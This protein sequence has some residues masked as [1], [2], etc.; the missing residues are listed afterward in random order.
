MKKRL[1]HDDGRPYTSDEYHAV[2]EKR[3]KRK[4]FWVCAAKDF[5]VIW[6]IV[7]VYESL[8]FFYFNAPMSV[9]NYMRWFII[10][11]FLVLPQ[12]FI[13]ATCFVFFI[14]RNNMFLSY[15][16]CSVALTI[17]VLIFRVENNI[18]P[19]WAFNDVVYYVKG[20]VTIAGIRHEIFGD[21]FF[22]AVI[23]AL[24]L[25]LLRVFSILRYRNEP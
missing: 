11:G 8:H 6:V 21:T 15:F 13:L 23:F 25:L 24:L 10:H 22:I 20:D 19:N 14:R 1:Y 16:L 18:R 2:E 3:A 17:H 7:T 12:C 4:A 9:Q 5:A